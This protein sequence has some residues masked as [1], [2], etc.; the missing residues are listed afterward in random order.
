MRLLRSCLAASLLALAFLAQASERDGVERVVVVGDVHGDYQQLLKV[1]QDAGVINKRGRWRGGKTHLVQIGDVPDRGPDTDKVI[2][3]LRALEAQ[4]EKAGGEVHALIGNHETMVMRGDLRYVHPGEYSALIDKRSA[5][6]QQNYYE[7]YVEYIKATTAEEKL[8]SFDRAYRDAWNERYPLG[9]VEHRQAW[10]AEGEFGE[11]VRGHDAILRIDDSLFVHGGLDPMAEPIAIDAINA[12]VVAELAD[13]RTSDDE[14]IINAADSP[15]WYRG[16]AVMPETPENTAALDRLL[17]FYGVRRIVI[18]HTP[19]LGTVVPRFDGRVLVADVGLSAYYGHGR[20]A[21]IIEQGEP[22]V[23]LQGERVE[24]PAA[25]SG[26]DGKINYLR[27][28]APLLANPASVGE[29]LNA[30]VR[31][32]VEE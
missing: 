4:A 24:L 14:S 3:L 20:A 25:G 30:I 7:R 16:L 1:L 5:M 11:W 27:S 17:A 6:R 19:L 22:W 15:L 13:A 29:Y 21:L 28:V 32:S 18:A 10:A 2:A 26:P 9:F 23:L 12:Q 31:D 8:P